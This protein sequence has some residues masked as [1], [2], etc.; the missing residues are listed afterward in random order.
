MQTKIVLIINHQDVGGAG[1]IIK[2]VA[3]LLADNN[4]SVTLISLYDELS[5]PDLSKK[6]KCV[7]LRQ[8][9]FGV[10]IWRYNLIA[11]IRKEI[12][13]I[14]PVVVCSFVSDVCF[15]AR[16]ATFGLPLKFVS[17]ERGDPFSLSIIWKILIFWTY[18]NSN[19]CFFQLEKA[20][21]F[22]GKKVAKK[23]FVI[24]NVF[25]QQDGVTIYT[26]ARKKTIVSAGRFDYQK[27]YDVLIRAFANI[28]KKHP[29]YS[30]I[31][32]GDGTLLDYFRKLVSDLGI[33]KVVSFPG[34]VSAVA[35][36][37]REE[38]IFVLSS[39]FEG[40]PNSMIEAMSIG[41]PCIAT[42]CTPGG[43]E[44]LSK[45]G[46]NAALVEVDDIMG[47]TNAILKVIEDREYANYLSAHGCEIIQELK[48]E[49][50]DQMWINSFLLI[51][52]S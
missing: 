15:L 45:N 35:N 44:F 5:S 38:G 7:C 37:I 1:K 40:I 52:E 28:Y 9:I 36:S 24:P 25:K 18:R 19:Y 41:I 11:K 48:P 26:E 27:G 47:L 21:D 6:V 3:N 31:L 16:I 34:Y 32:F 8:K 20:R 39:R 30:L 29:D 17:A 50:I 13:A 12:K 49:R 43:P 2:Y 22:F 14:E 51:T 10:I 42:K 23:S 33:E 4:Y 46:K